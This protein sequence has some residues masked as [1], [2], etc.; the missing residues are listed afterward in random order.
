M[1]TFIKYKDQFFNLY[2]LIWDSI[3]NFCISSHMEQENVVEVKKTFHENELPHIF[4]CYVNGELHGY[5]M[6]WDI[7]GHL[8]ISENYQKGVRH[9]WRIA[10]DPK[11]SIL[12]KRWY[13]N[14]QESYEPK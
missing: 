5:K 13:E 12:A 4:A 11:G 14:G 2:E 6:T 3:L 8:H 7:H 10:Y 1:A 9:G